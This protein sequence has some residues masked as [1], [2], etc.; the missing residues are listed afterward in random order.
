MEDQRPSPNYAWFAPD[1]RTPETPT[2]KSAV[3]IEWPVDW[4]DVRLYPVTD[5]IADKIRAMNGRHG[6]SAQFNSSRF[7]D[8]AGLLLTSQQETVAGPAVTQA[9]HQEAER[10]RQNGTTLVLPTAFE[11]PRPDWHDGYPKQAALVVGWPP[12]L[13]NLRRSRTCCNCLHQPH[14]RPDRSG[15]LEP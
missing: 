7:R 8:L 6:D 11:A 15:N 13:R 5:H 3:D 14:T 1:L 10:R 9:L 2:P 12:R 4:P